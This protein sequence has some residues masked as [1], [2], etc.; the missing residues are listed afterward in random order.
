[1]GQN[2]KASVPPF[3]LTLTMDLVIS[4]GVGQKKSDKLLYTYAV[5]YLFK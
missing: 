5:R 2:F 4:H 3:S 1:M